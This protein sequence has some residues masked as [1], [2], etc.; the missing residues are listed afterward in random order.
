[1]GIFIFVLSL[2]MLIGV[3][4]LFN[5]SGS[6][7]FRSAYTSHEHHLNQMNLSRASSRRISGMANFATATGGIAAFMAVLVISMHLFY[8][9]NKVLTFI[10]LFLAIFNIVAAQARMGYLTFVF[11]LIVFYFIYNVV[12]KNSFRFIKST[13]VLTA[14]SAIVSAAIY[15]LYQNGN[16]FVLKAIYRWEALGDQID[17]GGNRAGQIKPA[18]DQIDDPFTF[19]FGIS[20]GIQETLNGVHMEIEPLSIFVLY[21]AVGFFLMYSLVAILLFYFYKN[22]KIL[23][24]KPI[25]LAMTV[26]S[27][28]GL[29]SYIFFSGAYWFY[30]EIYVGLYPW[31]LMG[32]TIGAIERFKKNPE[33]FDEEQENP[34]VKEKKKR[35]KYKI[36]W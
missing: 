25:L 5:W 23:K 27:F 19:L 3:F 10:G 32:A 9:K 16:S 29:I 4:Q 31:I 14:L 20:R 21:G 28:V 36:V 33:A 15:K 34:D 26:S 24:N 12:Y 6:G 17:Q 30:R 22:I 8:K 13:F 7:F 1:M 35:K 11:S 18:L 2:G